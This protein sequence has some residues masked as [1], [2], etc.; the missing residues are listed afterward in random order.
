V[1]EDVVVIGR[2][3]DCSQTAIDLAEVAGMIPYEILC[4]IGKRVTRRYVH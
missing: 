3:G 4:G 2:Q 1:G